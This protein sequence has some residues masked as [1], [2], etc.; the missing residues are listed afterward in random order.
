VAKET[1]RGNAA[2]A[3]GADPD[4]DTNAHPLTARIGPPR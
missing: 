1:T 3:E 4:A 2:V